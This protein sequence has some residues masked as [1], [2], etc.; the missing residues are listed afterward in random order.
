MT[1]TKTYISSDI[2]KIIDQLS[3]FSVGFDRAFNTLRTANHRDGGYPPYNI[4]QNSE[5]SFTIELA[6]AGFSKGDFNIE[7]KPEDNNLLVWV[8]AKDDKVAKEEYLHKGVAL[9]GFHKTFTLADN[10]EVETATFVDGMLRIPLKRI[11]PDEKKA[12]TVKVK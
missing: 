3:P 1:S 5:E 10:V 2:N 8:E 6:C 4:I 12:R 11:I 9:R 7:V